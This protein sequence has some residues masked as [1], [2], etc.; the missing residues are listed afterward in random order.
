MNGA[1]GPVLQPLRAASDALATL[2]HGLPAEPETAR[3]T[4][5]RVIEAI[6]L[7][8]RR[9]LRDD[10]DAPLPLRLSA[11]ARDELPPEQLIT[12]LRQRDRIGIE[13]AASFHELL[14]IRRRLA[15]GE[16][17]LPRDAEL[18]V[19]VAG[20][21]ERDAALSERALAFPPPPSSP[22]A[23]PEFIEDEY[24]EPVPSLVRSRHGFPYWLWAVGALGLV[25]LVLLG[26]WL[27]RGRTDPGL[28]EGIALFRSGEY[29]RAA[30]YFRRYA[31][32]RPGDPTP[33]L[34]LARIYRRTGQPDS[35]AAELRRALDLAPDDAG[36][37]RELGLLFLDLGQPDAAIARFRRA[38]ELD[39]Q[40]TE[41]WIMLIQ[42]LRA[43]GQHGAAQRVLAQA[44]AEVRALL[45][46][47]EGTRPPP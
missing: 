9:L 3:R 8:L 24:H 6:E 41:G 4:I 32:T 12:E 26:V 23:A 17:V 29:A 43:G 18:A 38:V 37:Y 40:H 30:P 39:P 7:S 19:R 13:L 35:A 25:L 47:G 44:P 27:T 34:Y 10:P 45:R 22:A 14:G 11:L 16:E 15:A 21:L 36:V 33:R 46:E 1:G 2:R 42:A 5:L 20:Q 28:D 31:D